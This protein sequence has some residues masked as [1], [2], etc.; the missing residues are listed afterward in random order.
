[1]AAATTKFSDKTTLVC[2][3]IIYLT[4]YLYTCYALHNKPQTFLGDLPAWRAN[5]MGPI[6]FSNFLHRVRGS[7]SLF[8]LISA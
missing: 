7:V 8:S 3:S 5:A 6:C 2:L 1:M 4:F